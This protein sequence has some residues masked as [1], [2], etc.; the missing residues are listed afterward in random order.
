MQSRDVSLVSDE[1]QF[2]LTLF[3]SY[4]KSVNFL[5][6]FMLKWAESCKFRSG[7]PVDDVD[8]IGLQQAAP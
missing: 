6:S 2:V 4:G 5:N 8:Q 3:G 7:S 1:Y